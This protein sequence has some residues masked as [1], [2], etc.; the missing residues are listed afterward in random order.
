MHLKSREFPCLGVSHRP[1]EGSELHPY[2]VRVL[3]G[4]KKV[5]VPVRGVSCIAQVDT[6]TLQ[7]FVVIVPVRGVSCISPMPSIRSRPQLSSSP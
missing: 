6:S 5:I 2:E 4:E 1:R 3:L 7:H